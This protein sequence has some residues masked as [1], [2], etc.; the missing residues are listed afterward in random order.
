VVHALF[1]AGIQALKNS[2]DPKNPTKVADALRVMR[3][4]TVIGQLDFAGS[5]IKNVSKMRVVGGQWRN[6]SAGKQ[7]IFITH[8]RTA[9]E[10]SVQRKFELLKS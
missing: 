8:N 6:S 3:L 7:D 2:G 1:E 4:N 9:P 10:I 5:G